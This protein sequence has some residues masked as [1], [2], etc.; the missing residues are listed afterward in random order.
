MI[1]IH[2]GVIYRENFKVSP[3]RKVIDKLFELR[4]KYKDENNFLHLLVELIMITLYGEQRRKDTEE[5]YKCKSEHWMMTQYDERTLDYGKINYG[6]YFVKMKDG[7]GLEDGVKKVNT[8]PLQLGAFVLANSKRIMIDFIHGID[9]FF[10]ND[11]YYEYTD[12]MYIENEHWEKLDKA[13]LLSKNR[14]QGKTVYKLGGIWYWLL[15]GL[16]MKYCLTINKFGII[17][18]DKT[19]KGFRNVIDNLDKGVF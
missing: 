17:D 18:E 15:L 8:M 14:L 5:R 11:L 16:K 13:G 19:F 9:G 3:F 12:G 4:Q 10:T 1:E 7:A 2:E 6:N